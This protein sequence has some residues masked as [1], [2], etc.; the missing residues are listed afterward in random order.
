MVSTPS[1]MR[2]ICQVPQTATVF[3]CQLVCAPGSNCCYRHLPSI[4]EEY[5][6]DQYILEILRRNNPVELF[7]SIDDGRCLAV[8]KLVGKLR[9]CP[10]PYEDNHL[11]KM[12]QV[13][14]VSWP[15]CVECGKKLAQFHEW[16]TDPDLLTRWGSRTRHKRCMKEQYND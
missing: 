9:R 1:R 13:E 8:T 7:Y 6:H 5:G 16:P 12:H 3:P 11:C 10:R 2:R 4:D 15:R 14:Y